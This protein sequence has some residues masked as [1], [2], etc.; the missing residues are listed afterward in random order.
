MP[1]LAD[2]KLF[3]CSESSFYHVLHQADQCNRRGRAR[4]PQVPR[5]VWCL[6]ADGPNHVWSWNISFLSSSVRD[7]WRYLYLVVDVWSRKVVA[8]DMPS[9]SRHMSQRI[10]CNVPASVGDTIAH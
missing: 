8:W 10:W 7:V 3:I 2:Q 9:W 5:S 1:A 4:L 6:R